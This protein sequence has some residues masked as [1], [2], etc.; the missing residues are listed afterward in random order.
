MKIL[1]LFLFATL[2]AIVTIIGSQV[3]MS[4][5]DQWTVYP[6][7]S[8]LNKEQKIKFEEDLEKRRK[9]NK[10][11]LKIEKIGSWGFYIFTFLSL[12]QI[13]IVNQKSS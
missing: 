3:A 8:A 7:L 2:I 1:K 5:R 10:T 11:L 9:V 13:R 4:N 12:N 6:P